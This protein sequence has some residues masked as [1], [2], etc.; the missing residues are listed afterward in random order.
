[1]AYQ[2]ICLLQ[3]QVVE[4]RT[5]CSF[6]CEC[7]A[8]YWLDLT[9]AQCRGDTL[10]RLYPPSLRDNES[11]WF[12]PRGVTWPLWDPVHS[13]HSDKIH[14]SCIK[15]ILINAALRRTLS[16]CGTKTKGWTIKRCIC[17]NDN[18]SWCKRRHTLSSTSW[19]KLPPERWYGLWIILS[20]CIMILV[21][22]T[23]PFFSTLRSTIH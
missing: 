23:F 19:C 16:K 5:G 20:N 14:C 22:Q 7:A 21:N 15:L 4:W 13:K 6:S 8:T 11:E 10:K 17:G 3:R 18:I 2:H 9:V 1:M 12:E